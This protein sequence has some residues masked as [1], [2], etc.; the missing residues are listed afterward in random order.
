MVFGDRLFNCNKK[1]E[2]IKTSVGSVKFLQLIRHK[3]S[4]IAHG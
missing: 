3:A 2:D 4:S 1:T